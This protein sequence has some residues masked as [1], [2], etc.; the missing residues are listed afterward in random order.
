[1]SRLPGDVPDAQFC[2][3]TSRYFRT[4]IEAEAE[5]DIVKD[6]WPGVTIEF[7]EKTSKGQWK[8]ANWHG[9]YNE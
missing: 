4:R 7:Y 6:A 3:S 2:V 8:I 5:F 9:F 1:M